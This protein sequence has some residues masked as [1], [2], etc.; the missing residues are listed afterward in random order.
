MKFSWLL[1]QITIIITLCLINHNST[2]PVENRRQ[3]INNLNNFQEVKLHFPVQEIPILYPIS[4]TQNYE[5]FDNPYHNYDFNLYQPQNTETKD[6][7]EL[8]TPKTPTDSNGRLVHL[9]SIHEKQ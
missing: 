5:T 8:I 9:D 4:Q 1:S 3:Y 6:R 2:L 7:E